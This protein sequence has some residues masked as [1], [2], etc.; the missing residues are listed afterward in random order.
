MDRTVE[1]LLNNYYYKDKKTERLANGELWA[2]EH[3]VKNMREQRTYERLNKLETIITNMHGN[4]TMTKKQKDRARH[5]I[6]NL[7]FYL[8]RTTE[9]QYIVMIIIYVKLETNNNARVRDYYNTLSK[10]DLNINQFVKFLV[11]LNK[12]HISKIPLPIYH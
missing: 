9:E 12:H 3:A 11:K 5:L 7:D 6:K 4:F 10:Y 2:T 1:F 8:G